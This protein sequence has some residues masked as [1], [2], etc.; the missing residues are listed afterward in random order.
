M[1]NTHEDEFFDDDF[2]I[3]PKDYPEYWEGESD[4]LNYCEPLLTPE[5]LAELLLEESRDNREGE[6][7]DFTTSAQVADACTAD[8]DDIAFALDKLE[9][10]NAA[11]GIQGDNNAL[12]QAIDF[13]ANTKR[14]LFVLNDYHPYI[15]E[16]WTPANLRSAIRQLDAHVERS[17]LITDI[18]MVR[19]LLSSSGVLEAMAYNRD[20]P[21]GDIEHYQTVIDGRI[22]LGVRATKTQIDPDK[23]RVILKRFRQPHTVAKPRDEI[24]CEAEGQQQFGRIPD[25]LREKMARLLDAQ[26]K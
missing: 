21:H 24:F 5:E 26:K 14:R 6:F 19:N 22:A 18:S 25:E 4:P 15:R 20:A 16:Q 11:S 7:G 13:V 12:R 8:L 2:G 9:E 3:D 17:V 10:E 1:S 23:V